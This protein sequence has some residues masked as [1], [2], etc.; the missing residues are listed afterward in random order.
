MPDTFES[1]NFQ[2]LQEIYMEKVKKDVILLVDAK[3]NGNDEAKLREMKEKFLQE[4]YILLSKVYGEPIQKF[5]YEYRNK[6]NEYIRY[7]NMT[8][9]DYRDRFLTLKLNDFISI[10]NL[11]M[12]NKEFYKVYRE[13]YLEN[14]Y[15]NSYVEFLNLP[16]EELKELVIKQLKDNNPVYMRVNLRKFRD[17][18]SGVLDKRLYNYD[19]TLNI[20]YLT[21]EEA[22]NTHDIYPHHCMVFTGVNLIENKPQRWKIED[23]YGDKEKINGYYIMNDNYFDEFVLQI[24]IDKKYL[25]QEQLKLLEQE[26]I[27]FE[28]EDPF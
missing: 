5:N 14:V 22:L 7:M 20:N 4:N 3:R 6:D 8:P 21:K 12:Y 10:G 27:E 23:S 24:I 1:M 25:S 26:P 28:I 17:K 15:Q 11:P 9:I 2:K 19:Q 13:K 16:I 18:K